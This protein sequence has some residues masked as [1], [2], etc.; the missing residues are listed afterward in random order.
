MGVGCWGMA[1]C[2][3]WGD[4]PLGV[5]QPSSAA[6]A[7]SLRA[8]AALDSRAESSVARAW[9]SGL[10]QPPLLWT[11]RAAAPA[12]GPPAVAA[13]GRVYLATVEGYLH[14]LSPDGEFRWSYGV[15]GVPVGSPQ[16]D[17]RGAVYVG[18]TARRVYSLTPDG[19]L[20]WLAR[21]PTRLS[22]GVV[23]SPPGSLYYAGSDRRLHAL[24]TWGSPAWSRHL[25]TPAASSPTV[26]HRGTVAIAT[27]RPELWLFRGARAASRI[28]LSGVPSAPPL[29]GPDHWFVVCEGQLWAFDAATRAVAWRHPATSVAV[30]SDGLQLVVVRERGLEWLAPE[31]GAVVGRAPLPGALSGRPVITRRGEVHAP[32]ETGELSLVARGARTSTR[33]PVAAGPVWPPVH[34]EAS[35]RVVVAAGA[36]VAAV[37]ASLAGEEAGRAR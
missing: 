30:S 18:T 20:R 5:P 11:F 36:V 34:H 6:A 16:V 26:A 32:L 22:T 24:S 23:W 35:G 4:A 21:T 3:T 10:A 29:A 28:E 33:T 12:S 15:E 27:R 13:D 14:A 25:G 31:D 8:V 9:A 37:S 1:A 7:P 19:H 2:G 17:R